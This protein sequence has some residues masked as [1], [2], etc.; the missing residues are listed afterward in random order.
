MNETNAMKS[1]CFFMVVGECFEEG[2][3]EAQAGIATRSALPFG[4]R[5]E[6]ATSSA[7]NAVKHCK[8][9]EDRRG[10]LLRRRPALRVRSD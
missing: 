7:A 9:N 1:K 3:E 8:S 10:D 4:S 5:N 6:I 2:D